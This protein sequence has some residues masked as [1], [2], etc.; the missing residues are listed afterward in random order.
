MRSSQRRATEIDK[1]SLEAMMTLAKNHARISLRPVA[2]VDDALVA[3]MLM[4]ETLA[5][6]HGNARLWAAGLSGIS[7]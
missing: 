3:I 1:R 5:A 7:F 2:T 4:E 6:R